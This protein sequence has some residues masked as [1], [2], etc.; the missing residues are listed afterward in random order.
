[1]RYQASSMGHQ[2]AKIYKTHIYTHVCVCVWTYQPT[3]LESPVSLTHIM[4]T[5]Y[6]GW[7]PSSCM[8]QDSLRLWTPKCDFD[9]TTR[10]T[11]RVGLR[12]ILRDPP[13]F[14]VKPVKTMV[15]CRFSLKPMQWN[16]VC[17]WILFYYIRPSDLP[18]PKNTYDINMTSCTSESL[19]HPLPQRLGHAVLKYFLSDSL[20]KLPWN[21]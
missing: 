5:G 3:K 20:I 10:N 1:M 7:I 21:R 6:E 17:G 2:P 4:A 16:T 19:I 9:L 11:H 18:N 8:N 13:Y 15:S 14:M 12:E